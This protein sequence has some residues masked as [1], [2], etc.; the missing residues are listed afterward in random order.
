MWLLVAVL[1]QLFL[2]DSCV[3]ISLLC[4]VLT[5]GQSCDCRWHG[6]ATW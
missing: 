6:R 5:Q 1:L 4:V 2:S 3:V